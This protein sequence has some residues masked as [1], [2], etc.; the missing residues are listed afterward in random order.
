MYY[1][2]SLEENL[3]QSPVFRAI[4]GCSAMAVTDEERPPAGAFCF[5]FLGWDFALCEF[6]QSVE[7]LLNMEIDRQSDGARVCVCHANSDGG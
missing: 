3:G 4:F 2:A 7:Y 5:G 6:V 1:N